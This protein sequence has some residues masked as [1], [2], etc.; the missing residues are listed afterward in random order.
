MH[1]G[2]GFLLP[3]GTARSQRGSCAGLHRGGNKR[4]G[5][6]R[7][8]R[9]IFFIKASTH[10]VQRWLGHRPAEH[11]SHVAGSVSNLG[12]GFGDSVAQ[13]NEHLPDSRSP[14]SRPAA[15]TAWVD[16]SYP[17]VGIPRCS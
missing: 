2:K 11:S 16:L 8:F 17:P 13:K 12:L 14:A 3:R 9:I 6:I 10:L 1:R 5:R 7:P 15:C 4:K